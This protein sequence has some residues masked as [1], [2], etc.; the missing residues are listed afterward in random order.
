MPSINR[1]YFMTPIETTIGPTPEFD[2]RKLAKVETT[3]VG[4]PQALQ[5][6]AF[7]FCIAFG[8]AM[9]ANNQ[10]PA[11]GVWYWYAYYLEHGKRLYADMHVPLQP[12]F[13][14]ETKAILAIFGRSWLAA[15]IPAV[16]HLS[17]LCIA[18]L[19][20]IRRATASDARKATLLLFA[21]STSISC[22]AFSFN[23]Y[24]APTYFLIIASIPFLLDLRDS[25]RWLK[26]L[27]LVAILG[28][29]SGLAVTTRPNDGAA[30]AFGTFLGIS[31]L[32]S[33]RKVRL[34]LIFW[35]TAGVTALIVIT[36]TGDSVHDYLAWTIL[37]SAGNKGGGSVLL[38]PF[39]ALTTAFFWFTKLWPIAGLPS[40]TL[41][42]FFLLGAS[43]VFCAYLWRRRPMPYWKLILILTIAATAAQVQQFYSYVRTTGFPS[44]FSSISASLIL[45]IFAM[46]SWVVIRAT[47]A[48]L[49][50]ARR[51]DWNSTEILLLI[52]LGQ[53]MS[54]SMSSG[55]AHFDN[56]FSAALF[57]TLLTIVSPLTL[58]PSWLRNIVY[59]M[60]GLFAVLNFSYRVIEP[61][62]WHTYVEKP[63][64][65]NR[66][67]YHHPEYGHMIIDRDL[68][69]MAQSVCNTIT[70]DGVDHE[71]LSVPM[72]YANYFCSVPPWHGYVQTFFDITSKDT[73]DE[74]MTALKEKPP[75]WILLQNEPGILRLHEDEFNHKMPLEQN[76]LNQLIAA[77][78]VRGKWKIVY[79]NNLYDAEDLWENHW[80]LIQTH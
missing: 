46:C 69:S 59:C 14:L 71:L 30:L 19:L 7:F 51:A 31:F 73:I 22:V 44:V 60:T 41:V 6:C 58:H 2:E 67:L 23:D 17:A 36:L 11:D 66:V 1:D 75:K 37:H 43:L 34:I 28:A 15:K 56:L 48:L 68:L 61:F 70:S 57:F 24:R 40:I 16:I 4:G 78:I 74:L 53:A 49:D 35:L 21:F 25:T 9:I 72:P 77:N 79:V 32:A 38:Q 39:I 52:P 80:I 76:L 47:R 29:F 55:G 65:T 13:M 54:A 5:Y 42:R 8:L 33:H 27:A 50:P 63:M 18:W 20:L 10:T 12:S 64:F 45:V 62:S 3:P 26:D